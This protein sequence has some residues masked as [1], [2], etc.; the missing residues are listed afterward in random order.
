MTQASSLK[1]LNVSLPFGNS[2]T[3]HSGNPASARLF[4]HI[5]YLPFIFNI[6]SLTFF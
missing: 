6:F 3:S 5:V 4:T 2:N 1:L